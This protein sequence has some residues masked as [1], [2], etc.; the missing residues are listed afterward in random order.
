MMISKLPDKLNPNVLLEKEITK[1]FEKCPF[2]GET[3]SWT[4]FIGTK[5]YLHKGL[6]T[7]YRTWYGKPY[8]GDGNLFHLQEL[9][10][11]NW[12]KPNHHWRVNEYHCCSCGAEWESDP[13]PRDID[14]K[15]KLEDING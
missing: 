14:V 1:K 9:N 6:H 2:C 15:K 12:F 10:P 3:K 5:E 11:I 13:F 7:S 8:E 4:H